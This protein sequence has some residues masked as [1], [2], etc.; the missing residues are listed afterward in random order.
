[1]NGQVTRNRLIGHEL[2]AERCTIGRLA[3]P[4]AENGA[5]LIILM[6]RKGEK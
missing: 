6:R 5:Y 1:M 4:R 2:R 3:R